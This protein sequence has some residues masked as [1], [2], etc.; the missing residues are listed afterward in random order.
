MEFLVVV[1]SLGW[2]TL[3]LMPWRPW[4]TSERLEPDGDPVE[5][6]FPDITV[7]IPA[8]NEAVVIERTLSALR[9]QGDGFLTILIDDQSS[10]GTAARARASL[11]SGLMILEGSSLPAGWT[12]KLWALEQGWR[13]VESKLVLLLDADIELAPG[14]LAALRRINR[15][16][17]F[18]VIAIAVSFLPIFAPQEKL[19]AQ[20]FEVTL[21]QPAQLVW[22]LDISG[23][24]SYRTVHLPSLYPKVLW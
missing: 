15:P 12:G 20:V 23:Q 13:H 10:D 7:L 16:S 18:V 24:E 4:W 17:F 5:E 3:L 1:G 11:A 22:E 6:D 19:N 2:V 8:R 21:A 9:S 14:M